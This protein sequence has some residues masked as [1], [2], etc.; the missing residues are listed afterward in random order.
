MFFFRIFKSD[1]LATTLYN[2]Y[3]AKRNAEVAVGVGEETDMGILT[4]QGMTPIDARQQQILREVYEEESVFG[5]KH[6][7]LNELVK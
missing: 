7:K 6:K 2:V 5:K 4:E 3:K 1:S